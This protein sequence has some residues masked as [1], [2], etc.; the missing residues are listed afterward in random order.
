MKIT[1][2]DKR[3]LLSSVITFIGVYIIFLAVK[4]FTGGRILIE[5]EYIS[6]AVL[7]S[8]ILFCIAIAA[9]CLGCCTIQNFR[10]NMLS[11][12]SRKSSYADMIKRHALSFY[13][14][15]IP[16]CMLIFITFAQERGFSNAVFY[17]LLAILA[18]ASLF[19]L[20]LSFT[21]FV[22]ALRK[23]F[24]VPL[25]IL[26]SIFYLMC[27]GNLI[28]TRAGALL[29]LFISALILFAFTCTLLVRKKAAIKSTT[30]N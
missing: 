20:G 13:V 5:D 29:F 10:M 12:M 6:S 18:P 22:L 24:A 7:S 2:Y 21:T 26:L 1:R 4:F 19:F 8:V 27:A 16:F 9:L 25:I 28:R 3:E 30:I 15:V 11:G 17:L 23:L 14:P